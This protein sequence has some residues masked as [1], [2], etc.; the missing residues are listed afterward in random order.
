MNEPHLDRFQ[1]NNS[2]VS[3]I[4]PVYNV[5]AYLS[6][7]L[8]S[9]FDQDYLEKEII[10]I[11]DGSEDSSES[12][13][14]YFIQKYRTS[15]IIYIKTANHGQSEA[16]NLGLQYATGEFVLF[17][18]SDD[19]LKKHALRTC[20]EAIEKYK[21]DMVLFSASVLRDG[22][23]ESYISYSYYKRTQSVLNL[24]LKTQHLF[25]KMVFNNNFIASPCMFFY[26]KEKFRS[27]KFFP[28]IIFEDNLFTTQILLHSTEL[29][30]VCIPDSLYVRRLR[31]GS[32]TTKKHSLHHLSSYLVLIDEL[33]KIKNIVCKSST[34][35]ALEILIQKIIIAANASN[36]K[37][38]SVV[39]YKEYRRVLFVY[40][41]KINLANIRL[42]Y[43]LFFYFP[44]LY[45]TYRKNV[46]QMTLLIEKLTV[47]KAK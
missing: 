32:T 8:Q 44:I 28:G 9:V 19:Y 14:K 43:V 27:I 42:S 46:Y 17:M 7:C 13:I 35:M 4:I 11:N 34:I 33:Y 15:N 41:K 5:E 23:V 2:V 22:D 26:K 16:R 3:V 18:D 47:L 21:V 12:I 37:F 40:Y 25:E 29:Y 36:N 24:A 10:I 1:K 31:D 6:E 20:I 38:N 39:L 30:A 45:A